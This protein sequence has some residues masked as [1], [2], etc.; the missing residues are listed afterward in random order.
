[1]NY[2]LPGQEPAERLKLLLKLTKINS[3]PQIA[4]LTEHYVNGLPTKRAAA[5]FII[6]TSNL[7][8][9]QSKLEDVASIVEQIK[10]LDWAIFNTKLAINSKSYQLSD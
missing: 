9:A 8:R 3:E 2:L 5:R 4:A 1:M 6:E 10:E 7:S